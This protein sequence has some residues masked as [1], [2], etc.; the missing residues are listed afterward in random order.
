[1][2]HS[3]VALA[4]RHRWLFVLA[5][6]LL[7]TIG[8]QAYATLPIDAVPDVTNVQVQV[9]TSAPGLSPLVVESMVTRPVEL[10]LAGIPHTQ[11]V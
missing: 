8:V 7:A 4:V 1:M 10:A 6:L 9:L 2:I 5:T 11:E 3:L